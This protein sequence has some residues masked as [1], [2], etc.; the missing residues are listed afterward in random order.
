VNAA[1]ASDR[2]DFPAVTISPNGSDVYLDYDN[3][4]QPWQS[5]PLAPPRLMQAVVRHA[6]FTSGALGGF[7]DLFRGPA[8]DARGS[9]QNGLTAEFLGDYNSIDATNS[10]TVA[11]YNDVR[12]AADCMAI[13]AYRADLTTPPPAVQ[14]ECPA[15]FGNSDIYG[16]AFPDPTP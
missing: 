7:S 14:S 9:S 5:S 6:D 12:N 15:N 8:R 11:V 3:F 13:D 16:G 10:G 1:P 4:L 2:P